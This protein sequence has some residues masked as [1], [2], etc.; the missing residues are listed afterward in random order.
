MPNPIPKVLHSS[1]RRKYKDNNL[2]SWPEV[3][4]ALVSALQLHRHRVLE[5][6]LRLPGIALST[7]DMCSLYMLPAPYRFLS[8]NKAPP[9]RLSPPQLRH[10]RSLAG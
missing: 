3:Q 9:P 1:L 5:A 6:L 4:S 10:G 2:G 7:V 8:T